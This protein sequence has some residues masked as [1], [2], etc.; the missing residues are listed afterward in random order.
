MPKGFLSTE[1]VSFSVQWFWILFH[2]PSIHFHFLSFCRS[3]ESK[4]WCLIENLQNRSFYYQILFFAFL[5][6]I[7]WKNWRKLI[8]AIHLQKIKHIFVFLLFY[9]I[10]RHKDR[11]TC[12]RLESWLA[13]ERQS[14]PKFGTFSRKWNI[15]EHNYVRLFLFKFKCS[16][17]RI[18]AQG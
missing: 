10:F 9:T 2:S 15:V 14:E 17:D 1:P 8:Y 11:Y 4:W 5:C 16:I 3:V 12:V 18:F 6:K 13:K 7:Y